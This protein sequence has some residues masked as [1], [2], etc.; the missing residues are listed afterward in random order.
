MRAV[1]L[2]RFDQNLGD[3]RSNACLDLE[4][5]QN[6]HRF[7]ITEDR[8]GWRGGRDARQVLVAKV[9]GGFDIGT[10]EHGRGGIRLYRRVLEGKSNGGTGFA[11]GTTADTVYDPQKGAVFSDQFIDFRR[12]AGL[13]EPMAREVFTHGKDE[14]FGVR[15][16]RPI[17][18]ESGCFSTDLGYL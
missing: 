9:I 6:P 14:R 18:A 11:G 3:L 2:E 15:H 10:G 8:H 13:D 1:F 5:V 17:F 12:C 16:T 4:T 7:P